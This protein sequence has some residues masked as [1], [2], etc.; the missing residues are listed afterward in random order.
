M[1]DLHLPR[2]RPD[3]WAIATHPAKTK[4]I[5]M[6]RRWG[7]TTMAGAIAL[8]C[9][10]DGGKCAWIVPTYKNSRPVWRWVE[11]SVGS[12]I[13]ERAVV[14]NRT[15]RSVEFPH[16]GGFLG[17]YSSDNNVGLRGEA[18][19]LAVLEEA[20]RISEETWTD[21]V[22]PTLADYDGDAL[23]ISTPK[24]RNWFWQEW[25]R[26]MGKMDAE[27]AAFTA[28]STDN[29]MPGIQKAALLA[30]ER[31]SE[32]TYRQEWLAEFVED[33]GVFR[34]VR[35]ALGAVE[36]ETRIEGHQ[37]A[38]GCD[39]GKLSDFSVF[40]VIDTT[41]REICR[42]ERMNH[43]DYTLQVGRLQALCERFK[44]DAV[45]AELNSIGVP[46]IE[47]LQRLELPV[48]PFQMT[49]ASKS[50]AIDALALAFE[51]DA[52]KIVNHPV[53]L[54]EL[55]AYQAERLPSGTFRYSAPEGLHD[56]CVIAVALAYQAVAHQVD[57]SQY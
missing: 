18:F 15:E 38:I 10:S 56:D 2:L 27:Q 45:Y 55:L 23:L 16:S 42:I 57:W 30:R 47:Q 40:A 35:E 25:E 21:V 44:P 29:P 8:A 31:V 32:R 6:G 26:G 52:L 33:A 28:P 17:V 41:A 34:R 4:A 13:K 12:L 43:I 1:S 20:A 49:N 24:G 46:I 37:Y 36:Q 9:A 53:L 48:L 3:Q 19:H 39:W 51:R 22:M 11:A 54:S 5:S 7:K 50:Q 14:T